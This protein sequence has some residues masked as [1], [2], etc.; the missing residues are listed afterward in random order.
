MIELEKYRSGRF[1]K[2]YGYKYFVPSAINDEWV[3][4][5]PSVNRLL[6]KAAVKLGE[7]NSFA[8][9]VPNIDLFIQLHV[10]KE[11][12]VSSRIEGTQTNMDEALLPLEEIRPERRNDWLEVNNYIR[13]LNEAVEALK[14]L[15]VS[16][17][18]LKNTH[19]ILLQ[20]VRGQHKLPGEYRTSQNWIGGN[21]LADAVFVPPHHQLVN[22]LMSDLEK[23]LNNEE[24]NVPSLI[25]IAIAHYQFETIH[26]FLDGNGRIGR[27]MI[28]LYLVSESILDK[29]LL[30]LSLF[31]EKNKGLYYDNLT[32]VRT[33]NDMLQWIKYFLV[34][35][36]QTATKAV[37]TL[38]S[39]LELKASIE[40]EISSLFGRRSH[41]A[42]AL[43][44]VLFQ[45]PFTTIEQAREKCNLSY[46]AANDLVRK[47]QEHGYL[48]EMTG[49]SRNRIFIFEP[50]LNIFDNER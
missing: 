35:I 34:G 36:E 19:Q 27:L 18:L 2:S 49:Q 47:M 8:R 22:E 10:T 37:E 6:E 25:R 43:L 1:E 39:I 5:T 3:W 45:N 42:L 11:A 31:F 50:Y 24:I 12:V 32:K 33:Q 29:P 7:L 30:Y 26:P 40:G 4:K 15:P 23:F 46:K 38:T 48:K 20:S 28:T 17:R 14:K 13:A 21:S 44:N 9:L 41:S 16:S